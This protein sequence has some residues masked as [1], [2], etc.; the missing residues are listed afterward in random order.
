MS[1]GQLEQ[2][3]N[4]KLDYLARTKQ[5][6]A[7]AI[8]L[9]GGEVTE[10]MTFR[11]YANAISTLK[12]G[13]VLLFETVADME[14]YQKTPRE[15]T[16][17]LIYKNDV[18]GDLFRGIYRYNGSAFVQTITDFS[19]DNAN[20]VLTNINAYGKTGIITGDG[21]YIS[22]IPLNEYMQKYMPV[23]NREVYRS[24]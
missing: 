23:V 6:I 17:A 3:L 24:R 12:N 18:N 14:A 22:N 9:A 15:G 4:D 16:L 20:K 10:D 13:D 8:N 11:Q 21:S 7:G 5:L 19:L 1:A 2:E